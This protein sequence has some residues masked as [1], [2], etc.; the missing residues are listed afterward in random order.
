MT[1]KCRASTAKGCIYVFCV[2]Q[3]PLLLLL[4]LVLRCVL[5]VHTAAGAAVLRA[6]FHCCARENV[7]T[8]SAQCAH[9]KASAR[10]CC[11]EHDCV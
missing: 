8:A 7:T 4:P 6:A 9:A 1:H 2:C 3:S 5:Y 11:A 10:S